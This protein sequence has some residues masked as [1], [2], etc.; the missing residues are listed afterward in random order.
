[1]NAST[2]TIAC[3]ENAVAFLSGAIDGGETPTLERVAE[4]ANLSKFHF[5]R[6]F[7]LVTG[8]T[9]AQMAT[10]LRLARGAVALD[11]TTGSV[12]EAA[13]AA[14]YGSSQAFAKAVKREV[15]QSASALAAE[16]DRL[17]K[18][19]EVFSMPSP[20]AT[21][22]DLAVE[23]VSLDP[24]TVI[25][26]RTEAV[27][28][29]LNSTY[30]ELFETAGSPEAVRAIL[31]WPHGDIDDVSLRFDCGLL[32]SQPPESLRDG[33]VNADV[34]GGAFLRLR[35]QGDY[36]GLGQALDVGYRYLLQQDRHREA[37]RPCMFHYLDDPEEVA[38]ADLRTDIYIPVA[39]AGVN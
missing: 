27:Y 2:Y 36:D 29:E 18:A 8:E 32:L 34:E 5:H 33:T 13:F 3:I 14:G 10:R 22:A 30:G 26:K 35:H 7:R 24:F 1:M 16:P 23:L 38:E 12:T 4:A 28:P 39:E 25:A 15:G 21:G 19:I 6:M 31:G 9:F 11:G 37:D 17:A 20:G